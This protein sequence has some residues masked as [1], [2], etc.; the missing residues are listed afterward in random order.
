VQPQRMEAQSVLGVEVKTN[1]NKLIA[2]VMPREPAHPK[3][4]RLHQGRLYTVINAT[5]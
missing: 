4:R 5:P 2:Q 3:V 1:S